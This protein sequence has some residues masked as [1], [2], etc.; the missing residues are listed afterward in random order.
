MSDND[1]D[2]RKYVFLHIFKKYVYVPFSLI[3]IYAFRRFVLCTIYFLSY[4]YTKISFK[5]KHGILFIV[6]DFVFF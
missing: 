1:V 4:I 5:L 2:H 6:V 3:C